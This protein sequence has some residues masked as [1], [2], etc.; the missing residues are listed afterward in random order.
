[1]IK[2]DKGVPVPE[3]RHKYPWKGMKVGDSFFVPGP[4]SLRCNMYSSAK[5]KGW[6]VRTA[7]ETNKGVE[8][9]RVWRVK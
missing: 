1:M 2:I 4:Y 6:L 5:N 7:R 9:L 3:S 8:G